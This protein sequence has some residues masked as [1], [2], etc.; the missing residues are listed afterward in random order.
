MYNYKIHPTRKEKGYTLELDNKDKKNY[1]LSKY[2]PKQQV[3]D[4]INEKEYNKE[5]IFIFF[6]FLFGYAIEYLREQI[7]DEVNVL[8]IEPDKACL[9][10][11]MKLVGKFE[12]LPNV[13]I[14]TE[15]EEYEM[16]SILSKY[17]TTAQVYNIVFVYPPAYEVYYLKELSIIL[18]TI[19]NAKNSVALN[20]NTLKAYTGLFLSNTIKN[21]NAIQE[22]YDIRQHKSKYKNVPAVVVS[23]GPSLSKNIEKLKDFK[24]IIFTGGRSLSAILE[25][26]I[27]PNFVVSIDPSERVHRTFK[28]NAQNK[29]P[30]ITMP[31]SNDLVV[32]SSNGPK[33]FIT[34]NDVDT[35]LFGE[36]ME[37]F[38][39]GGSV[40]TA[41]LGVAEYMGCNPIIMIGQDLAFTGGNTHDEKCLLDEKPIADNKKNKKVRGYYDDTVYSSISLLSFKTWIERFIKVKSDIAYIN[42]TEGGAY[43]DGAMHITFEDAIKQYCIEDSPIINHDYQGQLYDT[44]NKEQMLEMKE[45]LEEYVDKTKQAKNTSQ[46]L[47]D[48]YIL[49]K[50]IR[51]DKINKYLRKLDKIDEQFQ[52]DKFENIIVRYIFTTMYNAVEMDKAYKAAIK[53][54][55]LQKD[56]RIV[57][58]SLALY[59]QLH[60]AIK[61]AIQLLDEGMEAKKYE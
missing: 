58:K 7:G 15:I 50:G 28:E 29:F 13:I 56:T 20:Y 1:I 6:G 33:Y 30:L 22:G 47:K 48:E 54:S 26:D 8:V 31:Q 36:N 61:D 2:T 24:G 4:L 39:F 55:S 59:E 25:E 45:I 27:T 9:E 23:A 52:N 57:S 12:D 16:Q 18:N 3:I 35:T 37:R 60:N 46:K 19:I 17:I 38:Q 51:V 21:L 49:Y 43:I 10:E 34:D 41:C 53:E 42:S 11:Q 14:T 40:A 32:G 5:S 44:F